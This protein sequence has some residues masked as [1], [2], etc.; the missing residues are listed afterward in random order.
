M[1]GVHCHERARTVVA[2]FFELFK[3]PWGF[4]R[5]G[6]PY[7]VLIATAETPLPPLDARLALIFGPEGTTIDEDLGIRHRRLLE[8]RDVIVE[9][10]RIPIY[11]RFAQFEEQGQPGGQET[12]P[13]GVVR[14]G[15]L[16][17]TTVIRCGYDIFSEIEQLLTVGQPLESADIP[18]TDIHVDLVRRWIVSAGIPV[19][20][21]P[22][23]PAGCDLTVCLTHDIDFLDLRRHRLDRTALGFLYRATI[24]TLVD[25]VAGRRSLRQALRNIAAAAS[26]PLLHLGLRKDPWSPFTQYSSVE[27]GFRSTFFV[28]PFR[29]HAGL[30]PHSQRSAWRAAPYDINDVRDQIRTLRQDGFEIGVHGIDAWAD[31]GR[32][33]EELERVAE[34][35]GDTEIGVRMHW[36]WFDEDSAARLE[37]AGYA[38]DS[39]CGYNETVGFKAGT[40]QVFRPLSTTTL[41]E[42]PLHIQDTAMFFP[43]RL[44]LSEN[45][46]WIRSQAVRARVEALGGVLT[47][48][49]HDRSLAPERQWDAMYR[50]L[51]ASFDPER[52]WVTTAAAA[53]Q[54]FRRRRSIRLEPSERD[55]E[56]RVE[57][58]ASP[59]ATAPPPVLRLH[60]PQYASDG[61][62]TTKRVEIPI[63]ESGTFTFALDE[64]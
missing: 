49:W 3:T 55:N 35:T 6:T 43:R 57:V 46:A 42:L 60:L 2:E 11:G 16:G 54:W 51:L 36:L 48:L 41:L 24:G 8:D 25:L 4:W 9:D 61:R 59:T 18:T 22:A 20:E 45:E 62:L 28:I 58:A 64:G 27:K 12:G 15:R 53:V 29:D 23:T 39:T 21:I 50:R 19:A 30:R 17:A 47:F 1:I 33:R 63:L 44:H 26:L 7:D 34:A 14:Y 56:I 38:Y 10:E 52:V 31:E 13:R 37:R 32:G 5:A 40:A